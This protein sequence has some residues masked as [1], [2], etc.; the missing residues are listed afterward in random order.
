MIVDKAGHTAQFG[1][2]E[3]AAGPGCIDRVPGIL[4]NGS[5]RPDADTGEM[6]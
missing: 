3:R 2:E 6:A 1:K 4:S 5:R